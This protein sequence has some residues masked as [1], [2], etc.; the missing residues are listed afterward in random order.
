M[1]PRWPVRLHVLKQALSANVRKRPV[2]LKWL[3]PLTI[4]VTP[5]FNERGFTILVVEDEALIRGLLH[6]IFKTRQKKSWADSGS[7][8]FPSEW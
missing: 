3:L 4:A 6:I 5:Y 8:S 7:G 1:L 2:G